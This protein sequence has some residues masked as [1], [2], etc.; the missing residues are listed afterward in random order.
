MPIYC[1]SLNFTVML[2][3]VVPCNAQKRSRKTNSITVCVCVC[4]CVCVWDDL[5]QD[6]C[7]PGWYN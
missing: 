3:M 7:D 1:I 2:R 6:G 5:F 4:V